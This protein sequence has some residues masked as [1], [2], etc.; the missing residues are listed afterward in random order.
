MTGIV[1]NWGL[2]SEYKMWCKCGITRS[3]KRSEW[4]KPVAGQRKTTKSTFSPFHFLF[5]TLLLYFSSLYFSLLLLTSL[6][7][8]RSN[9]RSPHATTRLIPFTPIHTHSHSQNNQNRKGYKHLPNPSKPPPSN[10]SPNN[11]RKYYYML[12]ADIPPDTSPDTSPPTHL[13]RHI[14]PNTSPPTPT[15]T[16]EQSSKAMFYTQKTWCCLETLHRIVMLHTHT[17]DTQYCS[18]TLW[19]KAEKRCL[20][21]THTHKRHNTVLIWNHSWLFSKHWYIYI[22]I[23]IYSL[24]LARVVLLKRV[25]G[26]KR[27]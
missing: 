23:Y 9:R 16:L 6:L 17:K 18:Q 19:S 13:P 14:P 21:H 24:W 25:C 22:Y 3:K 10:P 1:Q 2:Y 26:H 4:W 8:S 20:T 27:L 5:Q 15:P 7:F 12:K 11:P